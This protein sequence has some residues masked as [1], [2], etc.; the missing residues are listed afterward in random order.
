MKVTIIGRGLIGG[1]LARLLEAA[2]HDVT[3]LGREGGDASEAEAAVLA[4]PGNAI[5]DAIGKVQG[6]E[7]KIVLDAT[8][9][10]QGRPAG[11]DSLAQ[12][13]KS[14]TNGPVAKAFNANFGR[15]YDD[16]SRATMP[17]TAFYCGDD[18]AREVTERLTRDAGYDP[19]YA[20]G[21][22]NA[23]ALEDFVVGVMLPV[24]M[25]GRGPFL[26]RIGGPEEL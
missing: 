16:V 24:A 12:Q 18:E 13:V 8:N 4:V 26:Y 3:T 14:L 10:L 2:G 11:V 5:E 22:E 9:P 19:V 23:G 1:G 7:G 20:G 6:I 17:P 25:A 21:L 15:L